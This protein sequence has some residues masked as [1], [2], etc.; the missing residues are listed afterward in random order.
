MH[1][2]SL[3]PLA[4]LTGLAL[5]TAFSPLAAQS[6]EAPSA[7]GFWTRWLERSER[8]KAEQP[9]W[10]TPVATTTPRLEQEYRFDVNWTQARPGAPYSENIGNTKGLELIPFD[11]VELIAGVP[12]YVVHNNPAVLD[13]WSDFSL[14]VKYRILAAPAAQGNYILSAFLAS[15]F[16]T[17][18]NHNGQT[19]AIVT[20]TLAYGKGWG[21][22]DMQGTIASGIPAADVSVIGRT[23]TWN[24][25]LQFHLLKKLW[26]EIEM[27]R[28][29]FVDGKND[30]REQTFVTPG[31]V[32][33]RLPLS[34]QMGLT[35]GTGV[36]IAVSSFHTSNH[37]IILST[38]LPF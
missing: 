30:G 32:V 24:H 31:L 2:R 21:A 7:G 14:L 33:G 6:D 5:L 12:G 36:Q 1:R 38:R 10:I 35:I 23:Y 15:T 4:A 25:T 9:S 29:W 34:N 37:T 20:P 3:G 8:A 27:N 22:F 11:R 13:G 28:T 16:P 19:K 18:T 17:G 26:P